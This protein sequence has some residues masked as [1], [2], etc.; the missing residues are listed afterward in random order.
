[1]GL[2]CCRTGTHLAE[3][4]VMDCSPAQPPQELLQRDRGLHQVKSACGGFI[5]CRAAYIPGERSFVVKEPAPGTFCWCRDLRPPGQEK[6]PLPPAAPWGL[7]CP[8][9]SQGLGWGR[10]PR[11]TAP[12]QGSPFPTPRADPFRP[13]P[14]AHGIVRGS[15]GCRTLILL[16]PGPMPQGQEEPRVIAPLRSSLV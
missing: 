4:R 13:R 11:L 3:N 6:E 15:S 14:Q 5:A 2:C 9:C 8:R 10:C 7:G 1:M 16:H 12:P